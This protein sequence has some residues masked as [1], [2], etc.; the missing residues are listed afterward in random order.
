MHERSGRAASAQEIHDQVERLRMQDGRRL[1]I[2]SGCRRSREH[3]DSR[4]DDR[5][6][7]E[8]RQRPRAQ[9]LTE[10]VRRVLRLRDQF[11]DGLATEGLSV[12]STD[13]AGGWLS[14]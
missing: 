6:D 11:V 9:R 12:G 13:D 3:E 5:A 2:F 8:R 1:E 14:G 10:P 7:A 4:A